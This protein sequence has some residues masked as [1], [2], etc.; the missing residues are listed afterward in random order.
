MIRNKYHTFRLSM[1]VIYLAMND[2]CTRQWFR[3]GLRCSGKVIQVIYVIKTIDV[4]ICNFLNKTFV[5]QM[6]RFFFFFLSSAQTPVYLVS[7]FAMNPKQMGINTVRFIVGL[8]ITCHI[9]IV[10][11]T[12]IMLFFMFSISIAAQQ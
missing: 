10:T 4:A 1:P 3:K 12:N 7:V 9:V 6:K 8:F 5:V 11:F 2:W